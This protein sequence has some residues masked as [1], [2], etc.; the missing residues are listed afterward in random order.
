MPFSGNPT[1]PSFV[2]S[3]AKAEVTP[4]QISSID[5][6]T[7]EFLLDIGAP[8]RQ[9]K[10]GVAKTYVDTRGPQVNFRV[11]SPIHIH[12]LSEW[13]GDSIHYL[14]VEKYVS[15][16]CVIGAFSA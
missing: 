11:Q 2:T 13:N 14:I 8:G 10:F 15:V 4:K 9:N 16:F 6:P 12:Q 1:A 5:N 3:C 7:I